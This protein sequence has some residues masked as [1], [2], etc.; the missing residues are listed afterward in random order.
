MKSAQRNNLK[1]SDKLGTTRS[2]VHRPEIHGVI[3]TDSIKEKN[4][5][6]NVLLLQMNNIAQFF[7]S[8]LGKNRYE[9]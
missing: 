9:G 2:T 4:L 8:G 3:T 5:Y 1:L 6:K 7:W